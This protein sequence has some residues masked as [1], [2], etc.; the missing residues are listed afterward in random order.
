MVEEGIDGDVPFLQSTIYLTITSN[1]IASMDGELQE[2][3]TVAV[4]ANCRS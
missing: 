2:L 3:S 1:P 4:V